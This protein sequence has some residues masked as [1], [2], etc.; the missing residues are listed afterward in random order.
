MS[1]LS[2]SVDLGDS[3]QELAARLRSGDGIQSRDSGVWGDGADKLTNP[4]ADSDR[5]ALIKSALEESGA[6]SSLYEEGPEA[7]PEIIASLTQDGLRRAYQDAAVGQSNVFYEF[8]F[9]L[10]GYHGSV[11]GE[12]DLLAEAQQELGQNAEAEEHAP[13]TTKRDL[14]EAFREKLEAADGIDADEWNTDVRTDGTLILQDP[15]TDKTKTIEPDSGESGIDSAVESL[16]SSSDSSTSDSDSTGGEQDSS[17]GGGADGLGQ[18]G[19]IML[20]AVIA[21]AVYYGV[22]QT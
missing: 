22:T 21:T 16:A 14:R 10:D 3:G 18:I 15:E 13:D 8:F 7:A 11:T 4:Y 2:E 12:S 5:E 20:V 1:D 9:G 17:P 19:G 6:D